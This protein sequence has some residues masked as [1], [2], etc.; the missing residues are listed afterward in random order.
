[1]NHV[2]KIPQES[3]IKC[4][5]GIL[6]YAIADIIQHFKKPVS[7]EEI[8]QY[9]HESNENIRVIIEQLRELE[10]IQVAPRSGKFTVTNIWRQVSKIDK[11]KDEVNPLVE[12]IKQSILS[13]ERKIDRSDYQWSG[14]EGRIADELSKKLISSHRIKT[15]NEPT[16]EDIINSFCLIIDNLPEFHELNFSLS[17][18]NSDYNGVI[19]HVRSK[20]KGKGKIIAGANAINDAINQL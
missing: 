1:M 9:S 5:L 11:C 15:G 8:S 3:R 12:L 18:I 16:N 19:S 20:L 4:S 14:G 2:I 7:I 13:P 6:E 17:R 10:Y